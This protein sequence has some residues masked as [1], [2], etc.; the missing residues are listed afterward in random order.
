MAQNRRR[1]FHPLL[2]WFWAVLMT[3]TL[4][5]VDQRIL[6]LALIGVSISLV[7]FFRSS[8][9]W[10]KTFSWALRFAAIAFVIRMAIGFIIGVPMPGRTLFVLPRIDL[11]DFLVGIRVGG[12]VTSQRLTSTL[13]E[14]LT[15]TALIL[16]FAA[17][18]SLSNPHSLLRVLP[19]RFYGIGLAGVIASSVAPQTARS[20]IRV[21]NAKRLRGQRSQGIRSWRNVAMPVLED[22]LERS[23]DLAASLES[24]GYGYFSNPTRYRPER[25]Q[26]HDLLALSGPLYALILVLAIPGISP[27]IAG[28]MI[29]IFAMTPVFAS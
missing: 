17:A 6:S 5:L 28:L 23:I 9:Y 12:P 20:I 22:S 3:T 16:I 4:F 7:W 13:D 26:R 19:K 10:H 8:N 2:W 11:P 27:L 1:G 25:W 18:N 21:R 29:P 14:A 24:R 15:L